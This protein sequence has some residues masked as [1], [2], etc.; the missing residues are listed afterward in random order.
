VNVRG[1]PTGGPALST[2]RGFTLV[3]IVIA[4]AI[5]SLVML[6]TTTGLRTLANTQV[7][8]ERQTER[9]DEIRAVSSFIRET[10]ESA[11]LSI[12]RSRLSL[13]GRQDE[14]SYFEITPDALAW[15]STVLFGESFGGSYLVRIGKEDDNLVLR[16]HDAT[17]RGIVPDWQQ[18]G[19]RVMVEQLEEFRV[20][21]RESFD[22]PWLDQPDRSSLPVLV[23]MQIRAAGRFWPE[24][25]FRVHRSR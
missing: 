9:I 17:Y 1:A 12:S 6:A 5:L 25:I 21:F 23:R 2:F 3:E 19:S 11:I 7:A 13:G 16:W 18:A 10:M 4:L 24:L 20:S 22:G 8:L 14:G 15:K